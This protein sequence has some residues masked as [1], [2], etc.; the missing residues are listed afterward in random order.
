MSRRLTAQEEALWRRVASTVKAYHPLPEP[1]DPSVPDPPRR[2]VPDRAGVGAVR[3]RPAARPPMRKAQPHPE[4]LDARW[5]RLLSSGRARP[6]RVIDLHGHTREG[7]RALLEQTVLAASDLGERLLLV[8]T[9][10]GSLP[11]PEPADLMGDRPGRGAIRAELPRW[12]GAPQLSQRIAA[13]RQAPL[14]QGGEGAVWLVLRR[15]RAGSAT[16]RAR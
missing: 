12:L 7:A 6:D 3:H 9:G 4:T 13:V 2:P 1:A 5:N 15:R 14:R 8:I 11:G 10:K 16:G